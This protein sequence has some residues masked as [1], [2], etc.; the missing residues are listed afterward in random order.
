MGLAIGGKYPRDEK[1]RPKM[2]KIVEPLEKPLDPK[3]LAENN[4]MNVFYLNSEWIDAGRP[5]RMHRARDKL[6]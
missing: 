2:S 6:Q 1:R 3:K 5:E 4:S